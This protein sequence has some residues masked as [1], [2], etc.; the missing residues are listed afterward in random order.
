VTILDAAAAALPATGADEARASVLTMLSRALMRMGQDARSVATADEALTI[1][2]RL[3]LDELVAEAFN[4]KASSLGRL[5]RRREAM[6]LMDA[7]VRVAQ[8]SGHVAA[9]LRARTN[10]ASITWAESPLRARALQWDCYELARRVGNRT[11]ANWALGSFAA[12][13]WVGATDW[14]LAIEHLEEALE[15]A[16]GTGDETSLASMLAQYRLSRDEDADDLI[17]LV[18]RDLQSSDPGAV[19]SVQYLHGLVALLRGDPPAAVRAFAAAAEHTPMLPY[20]LPESTAAAMVDGDFDT[21]RRQTDQLGAIPGAYTAITRVDIAFGR[22]AVAVSEG[23]RKE[24]LTAYRD[25]FRRNVELGY[26]LWAARTASVAA[27]LMGGDEP[28]LAQVLA[29]ARTI[30]R[31]VGATGFLRQ[32]DGAVAGPALYPSAPRASNAAGAV[33]RASNA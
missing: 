3:D 33:V 31:R 6:A 16:R 32:L 22:A 15:A 1:A 26:A 24:A 29:E 10:L 14:D 5:G 12:N 11:V 9:E 23:R 30:L 4:N 25:V 2:E 8:E 17:A 28:E 18:D 20:F 19:A 13:L 21:V 7:A 27:R